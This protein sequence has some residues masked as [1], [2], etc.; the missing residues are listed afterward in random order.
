MSKNKSKKEIETID[1]FAHFIVSHNLSDEAELLLNGLR[2]AANLSGVFLGMS[3]YPLAMLFGEDIEQ[4]VG[5]FTFNAR[6]NISLILTR[7]K[8][9]EN[10]KA[11][12]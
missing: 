10:E 6:E 1:K 11:K 7:I 12:K 8:E 4:Y 9:L 3:I 2:P 5:L